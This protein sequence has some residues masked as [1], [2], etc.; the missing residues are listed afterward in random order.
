MAGALE[1]AAFEIV[2]QLYNGMVDVYLEAL[3]MQEYDSIMLIGHNPTCDELSR[4]LSAP[5]SP[6]AGKLMAHHFGT[7]TLA[8]FEIETDSW[9]NL[10]R[11]C[12]QLT[13]LIR[14]KDLEN[15]LRQ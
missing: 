2:P 6:A 8:I 12:G 5:G 1:N 4:F 15:S 14:P 9:T 3:W 13:R 10:A 11:G 7:A